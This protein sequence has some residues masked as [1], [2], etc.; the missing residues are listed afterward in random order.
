MLSAT[1][2]TSYFTAI[3]QE[4][5][6]AVTYDLVAI[7][8]AC[9]AMFTR[10]HHTR[11]KTAVLNYVQL[12]KGLA[13][14]PK[15]IVYPVDDQILDGSEKASSGTQQVCIPTSITKFWGW[16]IIAREL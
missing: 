6:H 4:S 9:S 7:H 14:I 15:V 13:R 11:I 3:T 8:R 1:T 5:I 2:R 10:T 16:K 12:R